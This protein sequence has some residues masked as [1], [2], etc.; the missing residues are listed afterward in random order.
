MHLLIHVL[1][2]LMH[3]LSKYIREYQ[4]IWLRICD[5]LLQTK[6]F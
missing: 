5:S 3:V 4:Y 1:N 2:T 6:Y